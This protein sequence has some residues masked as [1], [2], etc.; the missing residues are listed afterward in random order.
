MKPAQSKIKQDRIV[1]R[2]WTPWLAPAD[3]RLYLGFYYKHRTTEI[4]PATPSGDGC[5]DVA[6]CQCASAPVSLSP[7]PCL[8]CTLFLV[9][10]SRLRS[11]TYSVCSGT[12]QDIGNSQGLIY[13]NIVGTV[14]KFD[15]M[16]RN[17]G[18]NWNMLK[19]FVNSTVCSGTNQ[20]IE[21]CWNGS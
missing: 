3:A 4:T 20:D 9:G 17:S 21:S 16:F 15:S 19:R 12:P 7:F 18:G 2:E 8:P 1:G 6:P 13:L 5:E 11:D 14:R 10:Y